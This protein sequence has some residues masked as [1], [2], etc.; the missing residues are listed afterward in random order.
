MRMP[1]ARPDARPRSSRLGS[2]VLV[3]G[4]LP[5]FLHR[6]WID[7]PEGLGLDG[8]DLVQYFVPAGHFFHVAWLP[9]VLWAIH[10]LVRRPSPH[11]ALA[12]AAATALAFLGG[13]AQGFYLTAPVAGALGGDGRV[14]LIPGA[15]GPWGR[16]PRPKDGTRYGVAALPDYEPSLPHAYAAYFEP[17]EHPWHGGLPLHGADGRSAAES[18]RLLD[19]MSVSRFAPVR[20]PGVAGLLRR[21]GADGPVRGFVV[22]R[23]DAVPRAYTVERVEVVS[24]LDRALERLLADGFDPTETAVVEGP[25][26][27]DALSGGAHGGPLRPARRRQLGPDRVR[28][29]ASCDR[30]CLLVVTDLHLDGWRARRAGG[31]EL[32]IVRANG[33]FQ[34]LELPAGEHS[35]ELAYEPP[36][37]R[38]GCWAAA[39]STLAA[40][41]M[42]S[43]A[44]RRSRTRPVAGDRLSGAG[45]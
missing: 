34:G 13:H 8:Y 16:A 9:A 32:P 40:L 30:P 31:A 23:P 45:G 3:L 20:G 24:S 6:V 12:L 21:R 26:G 22:E 17:R 44:R 15:A 37:W 42:E 7:R 29:D 19:A 25:L 38:A 41:A 36:G 14:H 1:A 4:P 43:A 10:A 5:L 2:A 27:R 18:A 39:A 33:I 28:V 35:I 11:T